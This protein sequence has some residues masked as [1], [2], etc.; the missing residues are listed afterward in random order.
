MLVSLKDYINYCGDGSFTTMV[1]FSKFI[2]S[3]RGGQI[4]VDTDG[5]LYSLKNKQKTKNVYLCKQHARKKNSG[6][7]ETE[8]QQCPAK[9]FWFSET[10]LHLEIN[11]NHEATVGESGALD[12]KN[13]I[14]RKAE[15][16]PLTP[17]QNIITEALCQSSGSDHILPKW[18]SLQ[19]IVKRAR[20]CP[21]SSPC[22]LKSQ[23]A[24]YVLPGEAKTTVDDKDF[25]LY[26][27]PG[28][29]KRIICWGTQRNV[30]VLS[31]TDVIMCD[32]TFWVTPKIFY[33]MYNF[34]SCLAT[35]KSL[36]MIYSLLP[37]KKKNSY[38]KLAN[39]LLEKCGN[40]CGV[41]IL[42][43][44]EIGAVNAFKEV[45]PLAIIKLCY[46]HVCQNIYKNICKKFKKEY[47]ENP[48]FAKTSRLLACLPFVPVGSIEDA[49]FVIYERTRHGGEYASMIPIVESFEKTYLG[50]LDMHGRSGA[51]FAIE[52]W[53][54]YDVTVEGKEI[55]RTNNTVEGFHRGFSERFT[56]AH[57]PMMKFANALKQQQRATD[58]TLNRM[59]HDINDLSKRKNKKINES[60]LRGHL[61][62][63][64]NLDISDYMFKLVEIIGYP[65]K[66]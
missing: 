28:N 34:H 56:G 25:L 60:T 46:F 44:F 59:D 62:N 24:D 51:I 53:N 14:K 43:D 29:D 38:L 30:D 55:P 26:D 64:D 47:L 8:S 3:Q 23:R 2:T 31:A 15:E 17:T 6:D 61:L 16:Q 19:A 5:Y 54:F 1:A 21:D 49:M 33:Q 18:N 41:V 65:V 27:D 58:F 32:G 20:R 57:P 40:L 39:I 35:H 11:H 45:F 10:E 66:M 12:M 48:E 63:F 52:D 36:P 7:S 37:D 9:L 13:M 42:L 4:L 50:T 22:H